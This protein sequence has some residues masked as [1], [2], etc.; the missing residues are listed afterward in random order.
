[1]TNPITFGS[2]Y[3][4]SKQEPSITHVEQRPSLY[5]YEHI[6]VLYMFSFAV[7]SRANLIQF[8]RNSEPEFGRVELL[9]EKDL[10]VQ[11]DNSTST[12]GE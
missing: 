12:L 4:G 11:S 5:K 3:C 9:L 6:S 1:M 2:R 10:C 7:C 8:N